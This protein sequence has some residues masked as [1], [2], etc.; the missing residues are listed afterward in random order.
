MSLLIAVAAAY[1]LAGLPVGAAALVGGLSRS[2]LM[3]W[4]GWGALGVIVLA[5]LMNLAAA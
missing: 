5:L 2:E 3:R 1:L 4:W